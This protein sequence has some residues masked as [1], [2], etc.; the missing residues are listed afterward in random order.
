LFGNDAFKPMLLRTGF[1]EHGTLTDE[2]LTELN[3]ALLIQ[4]EACRGQMSAPSWR[5]FLADIWEAQ[6]AQWCLRLLF[7]TV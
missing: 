1:K 4:R 7:G 3:A 2:L 5:E 6:R